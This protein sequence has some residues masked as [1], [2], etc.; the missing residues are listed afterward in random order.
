MPQLFPFGD[1]VEDGDDADMTM[2]LFS[3]RP[4]VITSYLCQIPPLAIAVGCKIPGFPFV[5]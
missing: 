2:A 4:G 1:R 3:A 5:G